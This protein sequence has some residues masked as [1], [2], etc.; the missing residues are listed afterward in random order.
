MFIIRIK[1]RLI[2]ILLILA[3]VS[4]LGVYFL[5]Q[6]IEASSGS[7]HDNSN[8]DIGAQLQQLFDKRNTALQT[9]NTDLMQSTFDSKHIY[10]AWA[11]E[12]EKEKMEYLHNWM[13]KQSITFTKIEST[14][15]VRSS[16]PKGDGFYAN[17]LVSTEYDYTYSNAPETSNLFR[18]GT[19]HYLEIKPSEQGWVITREWYTDPLADSLNMDDLKLQQMSAF[20]L[21]GVP[22]DLSNLKQQR[23]NA[24][25]YADKYCGAAST[26]EVGFKFNPKYRDYNPEGGDCANFASQMLFEA[27]NFKKNTIWNY[28]KNAGSKTWIKARNFNSYMTNS[29]R[30]SLI[31]YGSYDKVLKLSYNLMPGDYIAYEKKGVVCH[32]SVVT[33]LDSKG[34]ALVNSHNS[35]RYRVPWDLGWSETGIKFYLVRVNY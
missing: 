18:I 33:G 15:V 1:R 16:K 10:G 29:G 8:V 12:H 32:I 6:M 26:P 27:G 31:A 17:V 7:V 28:E 4:G 11:F 25:A 24:V 2:A 35:D 21:S 34:Y 20:I 19:Y 13:A 23:V 30:G 22:K 5:P 9:E 3:L 14:I